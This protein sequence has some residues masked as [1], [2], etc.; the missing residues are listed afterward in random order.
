MQYLVFILVDISGS[1]DSQ[2]VEL[3]LGFALS[4]FC[5]RRRPGNVVTDR[6][7]EYSTYPT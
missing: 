4:S 7:I 5:C 2:S 6:Y 1:N 3:E